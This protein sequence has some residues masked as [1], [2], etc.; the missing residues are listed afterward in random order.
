MLRPEVLLERNLEAAVDLVSLVL[1]L[2][3]MDSPALVREDT[4]KA[5]VSR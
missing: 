5:V 3:A 4:V 1:L 2:V